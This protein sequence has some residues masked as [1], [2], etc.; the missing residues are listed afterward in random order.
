[1]ALI[2][3]TPEDLKNKLSTDIQRALPQTNVKIKNSFINALADGFALRIFDFHLHLEELTKQLFVQTAT[4]KFLAMIAAWFGLTIN[5]STKS[6]GNAVFT[7]TDT[8]VIPLG[9]VIQSSDSNTY[10]TLAEGT[11]SDQSIAIISLSRVGTTAKVKTQVDH[12]LSSFVDV[13]IVGADENNFNRTGSI[14]VIDFDEFTYQVDDTGLLIDTSVLA[15]CDFTISNVLVESE[16]FGKQTSKLSGSILTLVSTTSGVDNQCYVDHGQLSGGTDDEA[17]QSFSKRIQD[18]TANPVA[19]FN[20]AAITNQAKKT[21]GVTRV[22]VNEI[23]PF[24]GAVTI[25]FVRDN[26]TDIIPSVTEVNT[27]KVSIDAIKPA[28]SHTDNVIVLAPTPKVIDFVFDSITPSTETMK[29]A[30]STSI[31]ELFLLS[32]MGKN[33]SSNDFNAKINETFD[34]VVNKK[35]DEFDLLSPTTD[36]IIADAE[37]PILGQVTFNA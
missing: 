10:I 15:T 8:T 24:A 14:T 18:R 16:G 11:I 35:L 26:D 36:I 1:M 28:V 29:A 17:Q 30:I 4:G 13:I 2:T 9:T 25:Y 6:T 31:K 21:S 32:D 23:T 5:P 20:V 7:G 27:V 34:R 22:F 33:I 37:I 19:L 12:N 3:P